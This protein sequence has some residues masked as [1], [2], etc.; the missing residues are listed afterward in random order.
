MK[1]LIARDD[2]WFSLPNKFSKTKHEINNFTKKV[3][4]LELEELT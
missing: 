4:H 3:T 2:Y 1:I